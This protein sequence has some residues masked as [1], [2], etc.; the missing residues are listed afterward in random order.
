[1][2]GNLAVF[3]NRATRYCEKV[4][5]MG[6]V[7]RNKTRNVSWI[8]VAVVIITPYVFVSHWKLLTVRLS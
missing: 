5:N 1:M 7:M 6:S 8:Q 4:G 2:W 3:K